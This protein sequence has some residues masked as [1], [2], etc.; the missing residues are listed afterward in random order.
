[1]NKCED[2]QCLEGWINRRVNDLKDEHGLG[3]S[4]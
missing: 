4:R 3:D 1:M 2:D